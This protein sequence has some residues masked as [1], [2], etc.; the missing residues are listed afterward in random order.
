[1][2]RRDCSAI[3]RIGAGLLVAA[4]AILPAS[5]VTNGVMVLQNLTIPRGGAWIPGALG[6]HFWMTDTASGIC[7][8]DPGGGGPTGFQ[9]T[10]C[11]GTAK[12]GGQVAVG[13]APNG[14]I[15]VFVPDNSTTST[16]VV[17]YQFNP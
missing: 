16:N 3:R 15:Y 6:G 1:M 4:A 10:N 17:R 5:A 7:R 9:L 8:V 12:S 13:T 2:K 14:T 11:N